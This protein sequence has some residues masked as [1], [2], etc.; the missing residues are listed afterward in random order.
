MI[1]INIIFYIFVFIFGTIVGSFLNVLVLRYNTGVSA[2]KGRSF[3]FSCGKKLGPIE[4]IPVLSFILQKG[5]CKGCQ[6]KISWQ[7]PVVECLTG[8]LFVAVVIKYAG[9]L[10]I[11]FNP[12]Y[13]LISFAVV[14]VLISITIYD[15]KHKIIPDGL[16]ITFAILSLL[17]ILADFSLIYSTSAETN[18]RLTWYLIAG[19]LLALP[20]FL[21]WLFSKGK[22]MGLGDPKLVLG[23]GWFLG[24][25]MGLSAL[26]LAFWTGAIYG[27]AL[28]ILSKFKWHGLKIDGKSEVPFAPFL[29]LG[30]LL[31]FFFSIDILNLGFLIP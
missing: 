6:S 21:I 30:F 9:L 15:F 26:V 20:L 25:I 13:I 4:L 23:I 24:P 22:W 12:W 8:L 19:P 11:M 16:V 1:T 5:K 10:G 29:I 3:C 2:M 28:L 27:L 7:Y 31:V 17:K 14:A 18:S